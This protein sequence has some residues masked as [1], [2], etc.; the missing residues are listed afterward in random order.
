MTT[1]QE[2]VAAFE[3]ASPWLTDAD[4]PAL[5]TLR[6]VAK[7]LDDGKANPALIAQFGL[8]YRNLQ[9]RTPTEKAGDGLDGLIGGLRDS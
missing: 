4:L 1:Y 5:V 9:K 3:A 7:T 6:S 2:A 8:V